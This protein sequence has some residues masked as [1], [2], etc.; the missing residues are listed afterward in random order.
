METT[1]SLLAEEIA[2]QRVRAR[3][4]ESRL[5]RVEGMLSNLGACLWQTDR[6][7]RLTDSCGITVAEA[8]HDRPVAELYEALCGRDTAP[9]LAH[10]AALS[11]RRVT[12]AV[13]EEGCRY[14]FI[15]DPRRDRR[16]R[17]VGTVGMSLRLED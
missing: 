11:G 7:L 6:R 15:V 4:A 1:F 8:F 3:L 17:V 5:R 13:E 16:G 9:L 14:A 2:E 12:L 10:K